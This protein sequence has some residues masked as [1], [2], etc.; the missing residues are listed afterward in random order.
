MNVG[1][2]LYNTG[3][4]KPHDAINGPYCKGKPCST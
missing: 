4:Y 3:H 2:L 1:T